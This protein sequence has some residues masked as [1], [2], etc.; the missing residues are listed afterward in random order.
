[1]E[2][3]LQNGCQVFYKTATG[4]SSTCI[5]IGMNVVIGGFNGEAFL[6]IGS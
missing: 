1:M 5:E 6:L 4:D 3:S 2:K